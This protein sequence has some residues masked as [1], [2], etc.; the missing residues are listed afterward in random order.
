MRN[1]LCY[2]FISDQGTLSLSTTARHWQQ[3]RVKIFVLKNS[4]TLYFKVAYCSIAFSYSSLTASNSSYLII[5]SSKD[6]SSLLTVRASD[7][8]RDL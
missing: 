8:L 5:L 7:P 4:L 2:S 3:Y 1:L 6:A